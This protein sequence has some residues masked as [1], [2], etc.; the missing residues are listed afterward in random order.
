MAMASMAV[1]KIISHGTAEKYGIFNAK[2]TWDANIFMALG[3]TV[4]QS[5]SLDCRSAMSRGS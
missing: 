2:D 5:R 4:F 3:R 1:N